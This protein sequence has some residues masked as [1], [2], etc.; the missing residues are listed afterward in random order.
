VLYNGRYQGYATAALISIGPDSLP[1]LCEN[2]NGAVTLD[3]ILRIVEKNP[4][5]S[6]VLND[7]GPQMVHYM[8]GSKL[9]FDA[10]VRM[11]PALVVPALADLIVQTKRHNR[12]VTFDI[13]NKA[14]VT[15]GMPAVPKLVEIIPSYNSETG[16]MLVT[17]VLLEVLKRGRPLTEEVAILV[18][19]IA[20]NE[21]RIGHSNQDHLFYNL[22]AR[23]PY[24][25]AVANTLKGV[26]MRGWAA[27]T[28]T[29]FKDGSVPTLMA[30]TFKSPEVVAHQTVDIL[31]KIGT[32]LAISALGTVA[33]EH[34]DP[35]IRTHAQAL[36][37]NYELRMAQKQ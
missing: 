34:P 2:A 36:V 16:G 24:L 37:T 14:L 18:A 6:G 22:E 27:K 9:I 23:G 21:V 32:P 5:Y 25:N 1:Q 20:V 28:L 26:G 11:D 10:V 3:T 30:Y 19:P 8:S 4:E 29:M 35:I 33:Q 31:S 13:A 7:L 15:I 12:G 17:S